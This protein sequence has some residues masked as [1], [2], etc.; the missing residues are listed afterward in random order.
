MGAGSSR[1]LEGDDNEGGGGDSGLTRG[2]ASLTFLV[3]APF[4]LAAGAFSGMGPALRMEAVVGV[5][6]AWGVG[7]GEEGGIDWGMAVALVGIEVLDVGGGAGDDMGVED[8]LRAEGLGPALRKG[9]GVGRTGLGL[10]VGLGVIYWGLVVTAG[11]LSVVLRALTMKAGNENS[12]LLVM[13]STTRIG[14]SAV[15]GVGVKRTGLG[16]EMD[17]EMGMKAWVLVLTPGWLS[18]VLP[19]LAM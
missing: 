1:G 2:A 19:A 11:W 4:T 8:A 10:E 18:A 15:L 5:R 13:D 17:L 6:P 3:A 16:L 14:L 12:W 9:R 7:A